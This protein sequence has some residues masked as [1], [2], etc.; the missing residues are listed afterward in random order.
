MT[1]T[2]PN[3]IQTALNSSQ[4]ITPI[5]GTYTVTAAPV[6]VGMST[7]HAT[8][9]TQTAAVTSAA[10]ATVTVDYYNIIPNTTKVLDQTGAQSLTVGSDG[11]TLT[12]S[13]ASPVA[14][15]LQPGDVL[16]IA[17]VTAAPNGLLVK[18]VTA[19]LSGSTVTVTT[20]PATLAD[21]VTQ[22]A[23]YRGYSIRIERPVGS[24]EHA[25]GV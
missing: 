15:S 14:N 11:S 19:T 3:G 17:P 13:N 24:F 9:T 7:Y 5:P 6:V 8:E 16:A 25:R 21:E 12:I 4:I 22:A 18:V 10:G 23:I 1:V 20:T 2:D